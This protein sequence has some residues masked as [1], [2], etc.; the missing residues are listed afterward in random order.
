MSSSFR[1]PGTRLGFINILNIVGQ[2]HSIHP[3]P[4]KFI[5]EIPRTLIQHLK[6]P[7][8]TAILDPFCG[9]GT[10]LTEANYSGIP[11]SGYRLKSSCMSNKPCQNKSATKSF[12]RDRHNVCK[13]CK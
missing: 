8:G 6:P 11:Y 5:G 1:I 13:K 12:L 3:Y 4:A 7:Y 9:S 2:P 10:T